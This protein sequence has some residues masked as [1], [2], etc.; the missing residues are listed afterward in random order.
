MQNSLYSWVTMN[1]EAQTISQL[2]EAS[3]TKHQPYELLKFFLAIFTPSLLYFTLVLLRLHQTLGYFGDHI[4]GFC[5]TPESILYWYKIYCLQRISKHYWLTFQSVHVPLERLN[6][7]LSGE[8]IDLLNPD[9]MFSFL[10]S[11]TLIFVSFSK[12]SISV[13][14]ISKFHIF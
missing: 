13:Y 4:W 12:I 11:N 8:T 6:L 14:Y 3:K 7:S 5:K 9:A 1:I 10:C 2:A